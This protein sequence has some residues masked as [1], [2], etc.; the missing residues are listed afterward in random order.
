MHEMRIQKVTT[1]VLVIGGGAAGVRAAVE[2]CDRGTDV[3]IVTKGQFTK[4]GS[5]FFSLVN[6]WGMQAVFREED[7]PEDHLEEILE[8]ASGVCDVRLAEILVREAPQ[9]VLDLERWGVEFVKR[10]NEFDQ[11]VGCF[12]KKARAV[13]VKDMDNVKFTFRNTV[14][15]RNI[16][17]LEDVMVTSLLVGE[18]ECIGA[19]GID[20]KGQIL[21]I[22]AKATILT[23]GGATVYKHHLNSLDIC[24]DGQI[25][26][27]EAGAQLVNM[28]FI[29]F[30]YGIAYPQKLV[31]TE[32][33]FGFEP[34]LYNKEGELYMK[35][36]LPENISYEAILRDR[37]LYAPFSSRKLSRYFDIGTY[38][39]I[40]RGKGST[41]EA[42]YVDLRDVTDGQKH[43]DPAVKN[44]FEWLCRKGID[45]QRQILEIAPHAQALNGGIVVNEK[46][47]TCV[48]GLFAAGEV[49][50]GP[51][52]ADRLGGNMMSLTQVFG[53][54]AGKYAANRAKKLHHTPFSEKQV[55]LEREKMHLLVERKGQYGADKINEAIKELM[56]RHVAIV[57]KESGLFRVIENLNEIETGA[58]PEIKVSTGDEL[59]KAISIRNKLTMAKIIVK[60][61]LF[62]RES[63]GAHYRKDFP[64][65]NDDEFRKCLVVKKE[66]EQLFHLWTDVNSLRLDGR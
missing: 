65:T 30:I 34:K 19:I 17:V 40:I 10:N 27:L 52:G 62:R 47:E 50:G 15:K 23:T 36:Y 25:I 45:T 55:E 16:R 56:W 2:A 64:E 21:C 12:G 58:L 35:R 48:P 54:R 18:G 46:A 41:H 28:E 14:K 20:N 38:E 39:E 8:A 63:R 6:A 5:S 4:T 26:A 1:D 59:K 7:S 53:A 9:R 31:F 32:K 66:K 22:C 11:R 51:H 29:Q 33:I 60:S 49:M 57:R 24:G 44:W 13:T 37:A 42:I 61:A 3:L 43:K